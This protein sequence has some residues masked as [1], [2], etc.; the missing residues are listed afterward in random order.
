VNDTTAEPV[1]AGEIAA[2]LSQAR[3]LSQAGPAADPATRAA[4]L[5]SKAALLARI[6]QAHATTNKDPR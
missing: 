5:A 2:L 6:T 4:Y 3:T 1:S